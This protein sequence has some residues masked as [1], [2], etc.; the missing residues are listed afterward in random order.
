MEL[1]LEGAYPRPRR[2]FREMSCRDHL[3]QDE[4]GGGRPD[5]KQADS[6][7]QVLDARHSYGVRARPD[8]SGDEMSHMRSGARA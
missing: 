4:D 6:A 8:R 7:N 5:E 1:F 3:V 2:V